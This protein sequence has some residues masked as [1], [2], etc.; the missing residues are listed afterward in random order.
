MADGSKSSASSADSSVGSSCNPLI[1]DR[2]H[3][4]S[5]RLFVRLV[6]ASRTATGRKRRWHRLHYHVCAP[7]VADRYRRDSELLAAAQALDAKVEALVVSA[8]S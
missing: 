6:R 1:A 2:N 5:A 3:D 4:D 7:V 8:V